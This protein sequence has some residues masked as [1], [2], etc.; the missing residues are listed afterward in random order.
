MK[1][2]LFITALVAFVMIGCQQ[3]PCEKG[4]Y[5]ESP[6]I[7]LVKNQVELYKSG[8]IDGMAAVYTDTSRIYRN[9]SPSDNPGLTPEEYLA[10]LKG[11]LEPISDYQMDDN[12]WEMIVTEEGNKWVHMWGMWNGTVEATGESYDIPI[13]I[14]WLVQDGKVIWQSE[15]FNN[16]DLA[17]AMMELQAAAEAEEVMEEPTE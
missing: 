10:Q 11:N 12:V 1:T 6:E 13:M 17:M 14:S 7:D 8:D 15:I 5:T 16:T 2:S 3:A 9:V 4:Y